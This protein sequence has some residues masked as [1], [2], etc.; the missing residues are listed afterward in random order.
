MLHDLKA[1]ESQPDG[2]IET[3]ILTDLKIELR[4]TKSFKK[5]VLQFISRRSWMLR[6][7]SGIPWISPH[8]L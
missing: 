5:R 3:D 2:R 7:L 6:K 1:D 4:T 8:G